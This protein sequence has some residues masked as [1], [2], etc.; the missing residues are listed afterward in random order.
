MSGSPGFEPWVT[1]I[2]SNTAG[3]TDSNVQLPLQPSDTTAPG[4][5]RQDVYASIPPSPS[6]PGTDPGLLPPTLAGYQP[7]AAN[8]QLAP[9]GSMP[10]DDAPKQK[11]GGQ[12]SKDYGRNILKAQDSRLYDFGL[13]LSKNPAVAKQPQYSQDGPRPFQIPQDYTT[14]SRQPQ[15][16]NSYG[17]AQETTDVGYR[18]LFDGSTRALQTQANY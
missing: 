9:D 5:F 16:T 1:T 10:G 2:P 7:P 17:P 11:W 14:P 18:T 8:V 6:T 3:V 4:M 12:T 13:K 15:L